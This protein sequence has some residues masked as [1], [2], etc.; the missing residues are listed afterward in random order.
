MKLDCEDGEPNGGACRVAA[1]ESVS[2]AVVRAVSCVSGR[3]PVVTG[4]D[5]DPLDPLYDVVD[6]DALD[7]MFRDVGSDAGAPVRVEFVYC[8]HQVCV[9]G[10]DG[11]TVNVR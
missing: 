2:R 8:G 11:V 6:P 10:A 7:A 1:D 3:S 4:D 9:D 5:P